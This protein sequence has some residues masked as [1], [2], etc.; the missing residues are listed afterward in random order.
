MSEHWMV[1]W[2]AKSTPTVKAPSQRPDRGEGTPISLLPA[3]GSGFANIKCDTHCVI[4]AVRNIHCSNNL[5]SRPCG[6][7]A[8]LF[9]T[10]QILRIGLIAANLQCFP[11][12]GLDL[13]ELTVTTKTAQIHYPPFP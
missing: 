8:Q 5:I 13:Q 9:K 1:K 12:E 4:V 2:N 7:D 10:S 3:L 11:C 6:G